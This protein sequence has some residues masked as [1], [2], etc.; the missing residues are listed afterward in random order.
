MNQR[1]KL[2]RQGINPDKLVPVNTNSPKRIDVNPDGPRCK[3]SGAFR[4]PSQFTVSKW[5]WV[6]KNRWS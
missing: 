4:K 3:T 5:S 1:E 2:L 6:R